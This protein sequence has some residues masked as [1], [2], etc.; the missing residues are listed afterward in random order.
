MAVNGVSHISDALKYI[1]GLPVVQNTKGIIGDAADAVKQTPSFTIF[2]MTPKV[3]GGLRYGLNSTGTRG[4]GGAF[5]SLKDMGGLVD[6]TVVLQKG[7]KGASMNYDALSTI[8]KA[9]GAMGTTCSEAA[10]LA[11]D[12]VVLAKEG[13]KT[14]SKETIAQAGLKAEEAVRVA[15]AAAKEANPGLLSKLKGLLKIGAKEGANDAATAAAKATGTTGVAT[16]EVAATGTKSLLGKAGAVFKKSG[17]GIMLAIDGAIEMFTNVIPAF[18]AGGAKT[19]FKQLGKSTVKVAAGTGG[20]VAGSM[21]GKTIGAAIGSIFPGA[22]TVIGGMIGGFIGGLLGSSLAKG[23][24]EKITGK[25]EIEKMQEEA[26]NEQAAMI[27]KDPAS[28]SQLNQTL[29]LAIQQD[30]ADGELS[31][32]GQKMLEYLNSGVFNSVEP[33]S[34]NFNSTQYSTNTSTSALNQ[35][36]AQIQSGDRSAYNVPDDILETVTGGGYANSYR[37]YGMTNPYASANSTTTA[38]EQQT[39][40]YFG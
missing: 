16:A 30:L 23:A 37:T 34:N 3:Y 33:N 31:E 40:N 20:F 2:E 24:A 13:L 15:K 14:G 9:K 5:Q 27:F 19:G 7:L 26:V 36:L 12:A 29:Q 39:M 25:S 35:L 6:D 10:G 22:G 11:D 38:N 32:D 28:M 21:A 17:A 1:N 4:F 18:Q 8:Y